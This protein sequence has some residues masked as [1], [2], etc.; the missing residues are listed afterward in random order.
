MNFLHHSGTHKLEDMYHRLEEFN[1]SPAS[2]QILSSWTKQSLS[3]ESFI[4]GEN[5]LER[6][7]RRTISDEQSYMESLVVPATTDTAP[8]VCLE[9]FGVSCVHSRNWSDGTSQ[10]STVGRISHTLIA[11]AVGLAAAIQ[12]LSRTNFINRRFKSTQRNGKF[13]L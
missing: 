8:S 1:D 9:P 7:M 4:D 2:V 5:S 12:R 13:C 11:T 6:T 3:S 10:Y